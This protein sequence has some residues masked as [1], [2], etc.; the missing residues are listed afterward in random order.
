MPLIG[1][2]AMCSSCEHAVSFLEGS[3]MSAQYLLPDWSWR[4]QVGVA[5]VPG[6][7]SVGHCPE[8]SH[9]GVHMDPVM[10]VIVMFTSPAWQ[11]AG[12]NGSSK[13]QEAF[14]DGKSAGGRSKPGR[15]VTSTAGAAVATAAA[16]TASRDLNMLRER[17]IEG[18]LRKVGILRIPFP[19]A[20]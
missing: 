10:P 2:Q 17:K 16:E 18:L 14:G 6:Q 12:W 9:L 1:W 5:T 4:A 15:M 13:W 3:Q 8:A 19:S 20:I 11:P 7:V